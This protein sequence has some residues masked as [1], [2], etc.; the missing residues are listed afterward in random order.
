VL[1]LNFPG[2]GGRNLK[3]ISWDDWFDTFDSRQLVFIF[4][5]H[6]TDGAT[7]HFFRLDNPEREDG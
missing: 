1:R 7:S 3:D 2:Y 5:E 6:K 4:Q